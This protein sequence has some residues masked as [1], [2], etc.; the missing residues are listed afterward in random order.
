MYYNPNRFSPTLT[1]IHAKL[2]FVCI[3]VLMSTNLSSLNLVSR[4]I[5]VQK[6]LIHII[7]IIMLQIVS[8][9]GGYLR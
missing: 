5:E 3:P 4:T 1:I 7:V 2:H 6:Q 8:S 9:N